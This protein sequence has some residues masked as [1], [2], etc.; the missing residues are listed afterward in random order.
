MMDK[1]GLSIVLVISMLLAVCFI[2]YRQNNDGDNIFAGSDETLYFWYTDASLEA[3]INSAALEYYDATG[4]RVVPVLHS[5]V[6]YL[7]DINAASLSGNEVPDLYILGSDSIEKAAMA[8]LAI[9]VTD[10]AQIVNQRVYPQTALDAVTY[11]GQTFA[12]PFYYETAFLLYNETYLQQMVVSGNEAEG[13]IEQRVQEMIPQSIEEILA[14]ANEYDAPEN[15]EN[16]F[17]WDVSDIFYNYFFTGAYMNVGGTYGDDESVMEIYNEDTIVCMSVYQDL[18][19]FFSIESKESSYEAVLNDFVAGKT[20]FTIATTDA[21]G[22]LENARSEGEITFEYGVAMLPGVDAE[23]VARGLSS[24][25]AVMI[26][27]Y[28]DN[29]DAANEFAVYLVNRYADTLYERT[30]KM[31]A[32]FGPEDY[33]ENIFDRVNEVYA[34]SVPLPKILEISNFWVQLELAYTRIWDGADVNETLR[35]LSE[36]MKT[37]IAGAPVTEEVITVVLPEEEEVVN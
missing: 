31:P 21:I 3:Y 8:G 11:H 9:P 2:A 12:Y 29:A 34:A 36:Q 30:Q 25:S 27:G 24:T 37:Q 6:E 18:H 13:E 16:I 10:P 17:L 19:Q 33:E 14:I 15:V 7:E 32:W 35:T 22:V 26:N 23:H 28:S 4:I 20:I 5:G 1:K